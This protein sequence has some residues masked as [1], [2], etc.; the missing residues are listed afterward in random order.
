M[1]GKETSFLCSVPG[2]W[3]LTAGGVVSGAGGGGIQ[4]FGKGGKCMCSFVMLWRLDIQNEFK[5][6]KC[7]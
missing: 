6:E 5:L 3:R 4:S 2:G 7:M 1:H